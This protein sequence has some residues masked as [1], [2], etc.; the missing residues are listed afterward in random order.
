MAS[1]TNV[2]RRF[3]AF[4]RARLSLQ[5]GVLAGSSVT[6]KLWYM[7]QS[8]TSCGNGTAYVFCLGMRR[9]GVFAS[10]S[11]DGARA[12]VTPNHSGWLPGTRST[13]L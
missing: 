6:E 1:C 9:Y 7:W 10:H 2:R 8:S 12:V 13:Y 3:K 11:N 5:Y 4:C